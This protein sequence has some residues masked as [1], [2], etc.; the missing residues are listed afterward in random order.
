MPASYM[1]LW[2]GSGGSGELYSQYPPPNWP[3]FA[4]VELA[5]VCLDTRTAVLQVQSLFPRCSDAG[6]IFSVLLGVR[7]ID[8]LSTCV[9]AIARRLRIWPF[10][11]H[12]QL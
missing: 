7:C 6:A 9:S 11:L 10:H 4:Y 8:M 2:D 12:L 1:F 3:A 5:V